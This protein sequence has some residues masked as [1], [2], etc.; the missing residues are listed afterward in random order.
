MDTRV[1]LSNT[2]F[3]LMGERNNLSLSPEYLVLTE[4]REFTK[5]KKKQK[6]VALIFFYCSGLVVD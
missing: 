4:E 2:N 1:K 6:K 5:Q 3:R